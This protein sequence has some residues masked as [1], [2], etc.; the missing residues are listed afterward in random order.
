MIN[1]KHPAWEVEKISLKTGINERHIAASDELA[2]DMAFHAAEKLFEEA[3]FD[4]S[5]IDYLLLCTQSPDY[6]LPTTAC[7]LQHRLGLPTTVGALDFN[8]GCSGFIYGL[9][10]SK[11]LIAGGLAKNVLLITAD[12]YSKYIHPADR[13]NLTIFGDAAAATLICEDNGFASI[14]DFILG[15]D[16]SG[17]ENL[18]VKESAHNNINRDITNGTDHD[19]K[20][21]PGPSN[22]FMNG[23]EIFN[24]T[25]KRVPVLIDDLLN[26]INRKKSDISLYIFHQANQFMLEHLR[27]KMQIDPDQFYVCLTNYGNTVSSTIPIALQSAREKGKLANHST[28]LLAGFGVGYSWGACNL[29]IVND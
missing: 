15:T 14:G 22:L 24:F 1:Q 23:P 26:K 6:M 11:G 17:W 25:I 4:R 21:Q 9:N 12:T 8:L 10:L 27:K 16:G 28:I 7:I 5:K 2:S 19:T 29:T 20:E 13:S 18:I 3:N